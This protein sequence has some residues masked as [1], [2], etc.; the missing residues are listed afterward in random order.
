[1][2]LNPADVVAIYRWGWDTSFALPAPIVLVPPMTVILNPE[3]RIFD[4]DGSQEH[5]S[6]LCEIPTL[7]ESRPVRLV[8]PNELMG[9]L[10]AF[11]GTQEMDSTIRHFL[12]KTP[13]LYS[14]TMLR[15]LVSTYCLPRGILIER[16]CLFERTPPAASARSYV[17]AQFTI[18]P[19]S[20]VSRISS[21]LAWMFR[22]R[23]F[24]CVLLVVVAVELLFFARFLPAYSL[25]LGKV[26]GF[27]MLEIVFTA[28][29]FGILHELGHA[30]ALATFGSRP[31]QLSGGLC[32]FGGLSFIQ[33]CLMRGDLI[34]C[35]ARWLTSE[36]SIFTASAYVYF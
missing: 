27:E 4:F 22:W 6:Y 29:L 2:P 16:G 12:H 15:K 20:I 34:A 35:S 17:H 11:D 10:R 30:T 33:T 26:G 3:L 19:A 25:D 18:L 21:R 8:I 13:S 7:D 31:E 5:S 36:V 9:F 24:F 14:E 1:M 28:S 23:V 32:T